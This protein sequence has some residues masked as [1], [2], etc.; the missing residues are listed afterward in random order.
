MSVLVLH[1]RGH[2]SYEAAVAAQEAGMLHRYVTAVYRTGRPPVPAL[3]PLLPG[4]VRDRVDRELCRRWHPA[5]LIRLETMASIR[6]ALT[7]QRSAEEGRARIRQ[8]EDYSTAP[9]ASRGTWSL[10]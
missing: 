7:V 9:S 8:L 3:W 1:P 6:F 5:L 2:F 4:R 10:P